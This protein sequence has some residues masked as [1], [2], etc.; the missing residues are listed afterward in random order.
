MNETPNWKS[1]FTPEIVEA[2]VGLVALLVISQVP[3][4]A[5]S[6]NA[7]AL[8]VV[9]FLVTLIGSQTIHRVNIRN[10][11]TAMQIE[12]QKA[13]AAALAAERSYPRQ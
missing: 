11:E 4:Y 2:V 12:V 1:I 10:N 6:I 5:E 8:A 3:Q 9:G 7:I 13:Q